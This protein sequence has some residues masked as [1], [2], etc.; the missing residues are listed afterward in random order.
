M[1][2]WK[3]R[4]KRFSHYIVKGVLYLMWAG[5]AYQAVVYFVNPVRVESYRLAVEYWKGMWTV[6]FK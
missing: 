2:K 1:K 3:R 6:I 5:V 4:L